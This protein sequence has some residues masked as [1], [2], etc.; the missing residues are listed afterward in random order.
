VG[1]EVNYD[2]LKSNINVEEF[3][4]LSEIAIRQDFYS[5]M[6][7]NNLQSII[8]LDSQEEMDKDSKKKEED[9]GKKRKY[10]YKVN[11][12]LSLGFMKDRVVEIFTSGRESYYEE[13]KELFKV[14]PVPIRENRKNPREMHP[15]NRRKYY[16][17]RKRAV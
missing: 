3:T 6:F 11:R 17:N 9:T 1:V 5:S 15:T 10:E 4:G 2:H 7:I 14:N 16:M 8:A 13:L 12:N